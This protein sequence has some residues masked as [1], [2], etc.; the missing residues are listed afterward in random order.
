MAIKK[1]TNKVKDDDLDFDLD[2]NFDDSFEKS[3]KG[4]TKERSPVARSFSGAIKGVKDT[5]TNT[6]FIEKNVRAALPKEYGEIYDTT[7]QITGFVPQ[8]YDEAVREVKPALQSTVKNVK[9][10]IPQEMKRTNKLFKKLS[11]LIGEPDD[12]RSVSQERENEI[13]SE[14]SSIFLEQAKT[15][16]EDRAEDLAK[17]DIKEAIGAKRHKTEMDLLNNISVGVRSLSTYN[18]R[19]NAAYQKK[20]LELQYRSYFLQQDLLKTTREYFTVFK[21]QNENIVNNTSLPDLVKMK[22]S[23]QFADI[24]RQKFFNRTQNLF[25]NNAYVKNVI[26]SIKKKAKGAIGNTSDLLG[27]LSM[28]A[29]MAPDPNDMSGMAEEL[30]IAPEEKPGKAGLIGS[31]IGSEATG[32]VFKRLGKYLNTRM[33]KP[34]SKAQAYGYKGL[35]ALTDVK[36]SI[37]GLRN[38]KYLQANITDGLIKSLAKESAHGILQSLLSGYGVDNT[39]LSDKGG[40][41]SLGEQAIFNNQSQKSLVTVIPGYLAR[42]YR[43]IQVL[44]TGNDKIPLTE[45]DLTTNKF[46]TKKQLTAS[47]KEFFTT[48]LQKN[49][50]AKELRA[51][52]KELLGDSTQSKDV[53]EAFAKIINKANFSEDI[54]SISSEQLLDPSLYE[55]MDPKLAKKVQDAISKAYDKNDIDSEKKELMLA[56]KVTSIKSRVGDIRSQIQAMLSSGQ[57]NVLM[58]LGLVNKNQSGGFD[59]NMDKYRDLSMETPVG[60]TTKREYKPRSGKNV[61]LNIMPYGED[62]DT[63][64]STDN[65]QLV[66]AIAN[67]TD[68]L[69]NTSLPRDT[70][71]APITENEALITISQNVIDIR[72]LLEMRR[73]EY[74]MQKTSEAKTSDVIDKL[75]KSGQS[76]WGYIRDKLFP[77]LKSL[78]SKALDKAEEAKDYVADLDEEKIDSLLD[79]ASQKKKSLFER[80]K[81]AKDSLLNWFEKTGLS[82]KA[83]SVL[84]KAEEAKDY[85]AD[86]DEEQVNGLLDKGKGYKDSLLKRGKDAKDSILGWFNQTGLTQKA[87]NAKESIK[88]SLEKENLKTKFSNLKTDAANRFKTL[89]DFLFSKKDVDSEEASEEISEEAQTEEGRSYLDTIKEAIKLKSLKV[90]EG[91]EKFKEKHKAKKEAGKD[92]PAFN[93]K[94]GDGVRDGAWQ[95]LIGKAKRTG[96]KGELAK[97]TDPKYVTP[98]SSILGTAKNLFGMLQGGASGLV[99]LF[100][101]GADALSGKGGKGGLFKSIL[102]KAGSLVP[103]SFAGT[104]TELATKRKGGLLRGGFGLAKKGIEGAFGL[105]KAGVQGIGRAVTS[106]GFKNTIS[107][108]RSLDKRLVLGGLNVAKEGLLL[109]GRAALN[110]PGALLKGA[111]NVGRF[112]LPFLGGTGIAAAG[113]LAPLLLNPFTYAAAAGF[114][115]YKL[116]KYATRN[117]ASDIDI[118]RLRQYGLTEDNKSS[119]HIVFE[120][121]NLVQEKVLRYYEQGV[122]MN[123]TALGDGDLVKDMLDMFDID[124]KDEERKAA[125]SQWFL[126]RFKP[127]IEKHAHALF[128]VNKKL[129]L[130]ETK[131]LKSKELERYLNSVKAIPDTV[132]SVRVSPFEDIS[133][134]T[135]TKQDAETVINN[136]L[137]EVK[138][139]GEKVD[140]GGKHVLE[141]IDPSIKSSVVMASVIPTDLAGKAYNY[142]RNKGKPVLDF[143]SGIGSNIKSGFKLGLNA[144]MGSSA[145]KFLAGLFSTIIAPIDKILTD[146]ISAF[147]AVRLKAYG[148]PKL[149]MSK[150]NSLLSLES[151]LAQY[152]KMDGNNNAVFNGD[153]EEVLSE[154]GKY[155]GISSPSDPRAGDWMQWFKDRFLPTY[156]VY[157]GTS[158]QYCKTTNPATISVSLRE[159][160]Q[161]DVAMKIMG[162]KDIWDIKTSPW[163]DMPLN[164]NPQSTENNLNYLKDKT[165]DRI[166]KEQG[167]DSSTKDENAKTVQRL[168]DEGKLESSF[169]GKLW[170]D[171]KN[172]ASRAWNATKEVV[173]G[174]WDSVKEGAGKAWDA[175]TTYAGKAMTAM[176]GD[177][178]ETEP[179]DTTPVEGG[180]YSVGGKGMVPVDEQ[181]GHS[182]RKLPITG[183]LKALLARA[184]AAAGIDKVVVF[185]GGQPATGSNR[186]GSHRHDFGNAADIRL[187]KDGKHLAHSSPNDLPYYKSFAKAA[188]SLGATGIGA[189]PGYMGPTAMHVGFGPKTT[190]GRGGRSANA[191]EWLKQA[192]NAGWKGGGDDAFKI[193][194]DAANTT[195]SSIENKKPSTSSEYGATGAT[196]TL[197]AG[198][199]GATGKRG[200]PVDSTEKEPLDKIVKPIA[201]GSG[202]NTG[203]KP[204]PGAVSD[205]FPITTGA[206]KGNPTVT[207]AITGGGDSFTSKAPW[208][209]KNLMN[210]FGLTAV[211]AAAILGN[212]GHE[213]GGFKFMREIGK[214]G[215]SGGFGWAQWTYPPRKRGFM[216]YAKKRGL[217]WKSDE[218]NYGYLIEELKG[219]YSGAIAALKKTNT[220]EDGVKA[221][222][223]VFERAALP[224]VNYAQRNRYGKLAL[225][226]LMGSG[227]ASGPDNTGETMVASGGESSGTTATG[228]GSSQPLP[229]KMFRSL[230]TVDAPTDIR[231]PPGA[232]TTMA[233]NNGMMPVSLTTQQQNMYS[234]FVGPVKP[235]VMD[236]NGQNR[237]QPLDKGG[238]I[239]F[240]G[241]SKTAESINDTLTKSLDVQ[242][243]MLVVLKTMAQNMSPEAFS[244][245]VKGMT[246]ISSKDTKPTS[247]VIKT[248]NK[249]PEQIP[250]APIS[251]TRTNI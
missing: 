188:A 249:R 110:A 174:A 86:L 166:L 215:S 80:G 140:G 160:D 147:T 69:T 228:A 240:G 19:V 39:L 6:A 144:L 157:I 42:I 167:S 156:L 214:S 222:E 200:T 180:G 105:G 176:A 52:A 96:F 172:L 127:V 195:K 45:F 216:E 103:E 91:I 221:F 210:E 155:F 68:K 151:K 201:L 58:D 66:D 183:K 38:S 164:V 224:T 84:D 135:A 124:E 11:E 108:T 128:L 196:G 48:E 116:Y 217:D 9:K 227:G 44:R 230:N 73:A 82:K 161:Y 138:K 14:L 177:K 27:E 75:A 17:E 220:L 207:S 232:M 148:L 43:E 185:S 162:V 41:L 35:R 12:E 206:G 99:D 170:G 231:T 28:F 37:K 223:R 29:S 125:F 123:E 141:K 1:L 63:Q 250:K 79:K 90:Q 171:T 193:M 70:E 120:L 244:N 23:E 65:S 7:K 248:T 119:Y 189:G 168:A 121:E 182:T 208:I 106:E 205:A 24:A 30:G 76:G 89:S 181:Q 136:L 146:N 139:E 55:D 226:A 149:E 51:G 179:S 112:A 247:P 87:E 36:G 213:S 203:F 212:L 132:Y 49:D 137:A 72:K 131:K 26:D 4:P 199:S 241:M 101:L 104:A 235:N 13:S 242:S 107:A 50:Y 78:G 10:L 251:L 22:K 15:Y 233:S 202:P 83:K 237:T 236:V 77:N 98:M 85:V 114:A 16:S 25:S 8:L 115:G 94:D 152:V 40:P 234:G 219:P 109:G 47:A 92:K 191:P 71:N 187:I 18:E 32:S 225:S 95:T 117:K 204:G 67:L 122:Q 102:T 31:F 60:Q 100:S 64:P 133:E 194:S 186:V 53:Q 57:E 113:A 88:G 175:A 192:V 129:K 165:K 229:G 239:D 97:P 93:D 211:Q 218:A 81:N 74:E 184:G 154:T 111:W 178:G 59:I 158:Y 169:L 34:G 143:V 173:G 5:A 56:R 163:G 159:S 21:Q 246:P 33:T 130:D 2:F 150:V 238:T 62:G 209:M 197:G 126:G 46:A 153:I 134:L 198:G 145:V 245:A 3:L 190:W 118:V 61:G 142:L 243:Q 20:T 54:G